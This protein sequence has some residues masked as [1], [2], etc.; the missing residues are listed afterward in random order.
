MKW[1]KSGIIIEE[2][3]ITIKYKIPAIISEEQD[4]KPVWQLLPTMTDKMLTDEIV[5][6][7]LQAKSDN[8]SVIY[9]TVL[10]AWLN[11][12]T[13][14]LMLIESEREVGVKIGKYAKIPR[15][16]LKIINQRK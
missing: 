5:T 3:K 7:R 10:E 8:E 2:S 12:G 4:G 6:S 14:G 1:A 16:Q 9:Q 13:K 15:E 11:M